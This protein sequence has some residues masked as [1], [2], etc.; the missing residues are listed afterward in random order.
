MG[1]ALDAMAA[2]ATELY[3]QV[4]VIN[5]GYLDG[6]HPFPDRTHL[7]VLFATFQLELFDL[8]IRWVGF[9]KTE[10]AGWPT[11]Q[12]LGMTDRTDAILHCIKERRSVL[13]QPGEMLPTAG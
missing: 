11:T 12:A 1:A 2:D 7:S 13:D 10:I 4:V 6:E 8:I 3:E 9:A 5:T